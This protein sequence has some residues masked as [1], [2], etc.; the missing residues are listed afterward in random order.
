LTQDQLID[1]WSGNGAASLA[2]RG[3]RPSRAE[4]SMWLIWQK[5]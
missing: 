4:I 3:R 1:T 5:L 2:D